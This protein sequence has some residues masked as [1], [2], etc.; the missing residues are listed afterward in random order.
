M[1]HKRTRSQNP[2]QS[3]LEK[4]GLELPEVSKPAGEYIPAKKVGNLVFCS[5]QGPIKD[6]K[7]VYVGRVGAEISVEEGYEAARLCVLNCLAAAES[8]IGSLE[9]V[10]EII[11]V[12]GFVNSTADFYRQ[13]EVINGASDVLVRVFGAKGRHARVA[14]GTSALPNNIAVEVEIIL[15]VREDYS[16]ENHA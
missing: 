11:N 2:F 5:G 8:V 3:R 13:P 6:G 1:K 4:L 7:A 9:K 10:E 15:K 14:V 12:R 16:R